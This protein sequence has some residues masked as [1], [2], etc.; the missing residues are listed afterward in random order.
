[1][2]PPIRP[3][4]HHIPHFSIIHLYRNFRSCNNNLKSRFMLNTQSEKVYCN[5]LKKSVFK[6]L[7]LPQMQRKAFYRQSGLLILDGPSYSMFKHAQ[8]LVVRMVTKYLLIPIQHHSRWYWY[9]TRDQGH[10]TQLLN[11]L[12]YHHHA[13]LIDESCQ[14]GTGYT[15]PVR[16]IPVVECQDTYRLRWVRKLI[17]G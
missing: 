9:F 5:R 6:N 16:Q 2:I 8:I 14:A 4:L 3:R 12:R 7:G 11:I 1:M 17:C 13:G 15:L 10:I